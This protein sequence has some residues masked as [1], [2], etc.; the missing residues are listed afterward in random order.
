LDAPTQLPPQNNQ[1]MP[2][3][4]V[5]SLKPHLRLERRGQGDQ[6][7]T[8]KPY[9][10]ASLGDS[11]ISSTRI[12]FS[13]HTPHTSMTTYKVLA[14]PSREADRRKSK[15]GGQNRNFGSGRAIHPITP[16]DLGLFTV[17]RTA[18]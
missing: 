8:Q 3:H 15:D 12:E 6:D 11:V 13:V 2:K 1:L 9:H 5:L 16:L 10:S 14:L 18:G 17:R 4:R 7:E